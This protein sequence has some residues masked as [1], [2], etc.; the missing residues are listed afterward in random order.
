MKTHLKALFS[1]LLVLGLIIWAGFFSSYKAS[2]SDNLKVYFFDVGQGDSEYIKMPNGQDVLI[3]GGPDNK[4]LDELGQVMNLGDREI[5]LI[6]LTHPHSDHLNGLI[7]VLNRYKVGEIW[8][9]GVDYDSAVYSQWQKLVADKK[10]SKKTVV[11]GEEKEF[12]EVKII[13]VFPLKSFQYQKIDNINNSSL[14]ERLEYQQFSVIFM[15][16]LERESQKSILSEVSATTVL[17]AAHHGA[18]NGLNED[19]IKLLRPA[20][21]VISVG[22]KNNY[23]HP[24][25]TTIATFRNLATRIYRTDQNG[26]ILIESDGKNYWSK[27]KR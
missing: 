26:T 7:E 5:D 19:L 15:G 10:I 2:Q 20:I 1:F 9:S 18:L 11:K 22:S 8:E 13:T 25:G 27:T 24:H 14:V 17:K 16:D 23:G 4:V 21:A 12:G 6:I 3:D